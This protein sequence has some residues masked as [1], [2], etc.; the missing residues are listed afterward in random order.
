[1][2]NNS[3]NKK[4]EPSLFAKA[5]SLTK[6]TINHVKSGCAL[7]TDNVEKDRIET[8]STC[9]FFDKE[10]YKCKSC[11][12]ELKYKLLWQTSKCPE[13]RWKE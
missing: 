8:C 13:N 6:A 5:I 11:G 1:M 3:N 2:E 4:E 9:D 12:C 7:V 10:K